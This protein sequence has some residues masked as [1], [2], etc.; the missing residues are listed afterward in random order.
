MQSLDIGGHRQRRSILSDFPDGWLI[1]TVFYYYGWYLYM[2]LWFFCWAVP[3]DKGPRHETVLNFHADRALIGRGSDRGQGPRRFTSILADPPF[4]MS[5]RFFRINNLVRTVGQRRQN[6]CSKSRI[7]GES[8][9][10][11]SCL[12]RKHVHTY[13][14]QAKIKL[15]IFPE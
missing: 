12:N 15:L 3:F 14:K 9:I 1:I 10:I 13:T 11:P 8:P 5:I 7:E 2:G 6:C 4:Q